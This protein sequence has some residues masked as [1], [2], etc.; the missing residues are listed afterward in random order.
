MIE[1]KELTVH[2]TDLHI[3]DAIVINC[4]DMI[5]R[6]NL[7]IGDCLGDC[8]SIILC[9]IP[10]SRISFKKVSRNLVAIVIHLNHESKKK[11][12]HKTQN[13]A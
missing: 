8:I 5:A 10:I 6:Q 4:N 12:P 9:K 2:N 11:R 7:N 3:A 1:Q 13:S